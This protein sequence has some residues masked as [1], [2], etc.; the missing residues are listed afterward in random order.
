MRWFR[1][2]VLLPNIVIMAILSDIFIDKR[3]SLGLSDDIWP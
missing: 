3:D 2:A 1:E